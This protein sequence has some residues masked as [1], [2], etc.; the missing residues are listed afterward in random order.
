MPKKRKKKKPNYDDSELEKKF[1]AIWLSHFPRYPPVPQHK[2]HPSRQYRMDFAWPANKL[3]VEI[4]GFGP[5]HCSLPGMTQDYTRH[6]QALLLG[7]RI[8]YL[9]TTHLKDEDTFIPHLKRLLN[10]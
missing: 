8:V 3:A 10:L 7:W 4:H 5:G 1:L 9:T 2:F 6:I